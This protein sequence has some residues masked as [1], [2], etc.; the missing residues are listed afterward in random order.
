MAVP[1]DP[2]V[3]RIAVCKPHRAWPGRPQPCCSV[4]IWPARLPEPLP[5]PLDAQGVEPDM[6]NPARSAA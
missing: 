1:G 6:L 3:K 4:S 2:M 5:E